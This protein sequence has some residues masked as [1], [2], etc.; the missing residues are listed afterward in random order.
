MSGAGRPSRVGTWVRRLD[1][2]LLAPGSAGRLRA[3]HT[4][5]ALVLGLRLAT[6]DWS[7]IADRPAVL[8]EHAFAVAWLPASVPPVALT[9]VQVLGLCGVLLVVA[10]YR[11]RLGF[12]VAWIALTVLAGLWGSSGKV[13]HNDVLL[14][15]VG[16]VLLFASVPDRR[17]PD[18]ERAVRWG[19]PP[20]AALAVL[21]TVYFLTGAQKLRHSGLGWVFSD[22]MSWV[23]RQG[24]SP[25]GGDLTGAVADQVWLT[26]LLAGGALC[27]ELAAPLLLAV[28]QTRILYAAAVLAMHTSIWAFLGL[29]YWA[30]VLTVAAVAVP[31][32]WTAARTAVAGRLRRPPG[33][34]RRS[35]RRASGADSERRRRR[36]R[37]PE[38]VPARSR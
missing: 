34:G 19:W 14:L 16:F 17:T 8:T 38:G 18:A 15:T 5:V 22:N 10:R 6:R 30:W 23:L 3:V 4:A 33:G 32:G 29:D 27:L 25:F 12:V 36:P 9:A 28:R 7:Q 20:R 13:M 31:T 24:S 35:S 21:A 26:Q 1:T 2:A 11:A 37:A